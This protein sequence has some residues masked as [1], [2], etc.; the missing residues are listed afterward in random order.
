MREKTWQ[1]LEA[2]AAVYDSESYLSGRYLAARQKDSR[3]KSLEANSLTDFGGRGTIGI[4]RNGL[5][6]ERHFGSIPWNSH[7]A[8]G[9]LIFE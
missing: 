3:P 2:I 1:R 8:H 7:A 5:P 6:P 4:G 9:V